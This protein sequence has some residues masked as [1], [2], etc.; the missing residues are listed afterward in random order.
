MLKTPFWFRL[1]ISI[2]LLIIGTYYVISPNEIRDYFLIGF[3]GLFFTYLFAYSRIFVRK[4]RYNF[5]KKINSKIELTSLNS[6]LQKI[7]VDFKNQIENNIKIVFN[8][9]VHDF[10]SKWSIR[11]IYVNPEYIKHAD[12]REIRSSLFHELGHIKKSTNFVFES[13]WFS[14]IPIVYGMIF[15]IIDIMRDGIPIV[16]IISMLVFNYLI[17]IIISW[18]NE[19][20]A[21]KFALEHVNQDEMKIMFNS[22]QYRLDLETHP[23]PSRRW[24]KINKKN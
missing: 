12:E 2:T 1:G 23:S 10:E 16:S 4:L 5:R 8:N 18:R 20:R 21:D 3:I 11:T 13:I 17:M 22:M 15:I 19:Y 9:H 14:M 7:F 24:H 6:E